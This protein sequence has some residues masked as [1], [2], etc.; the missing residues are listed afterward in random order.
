MKKENKVSKRKEK[1]K[2]YRLFYMLVL[3]LVTAVSL[4]F[5]SYAWFTT[6][7]IARVDLLNVNVR[8]Q[9][10]IEISVDGDKWKGNVSI[11]DIINARSTYPGSV[12][13]IPK[14]LEPVSTVGE[15]DS[16]KLKMF[17]GNV[18]MNKFGDYILST[19]RSIETES[20]DEDSEGLFITFDLFFKTNEN[21]KFYLTP[22]SNVTYQ[23][24]ESVGIENAVR[25]AFILE[26]NTSIGSNLSYIQGLTTNNMG[27]VY[28]WEPNYNTHTLYGVENAKNTYNIETGLT[29]GIINYD[30]VSSEIGSNLGIKANEAFSRV[31]PNYFRTVKVNYYTVKD[32]STNQEIFNLNSGITKARVYMWIEG[33]DVDCEN[34]A[35]VGNITLNLQFS[36]NPS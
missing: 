19:T 16:G 1:E 10:G 28:I 36:K 9:G 14:T 32:F 17:Y 35:S 15:I 33:Q 18:E 24:E 30:G 5:S 26:G 11:E 6:N 8:A 34:N 25:V 13:Q 23:G 22:E 12:N 27:D 31:Y 29:G 3:L 20:F 21:T 2:N 7:R 4:S